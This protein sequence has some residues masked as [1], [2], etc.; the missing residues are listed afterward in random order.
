MYTSIHRA[1]GT[2]RGVVVV[3]PPF[4]LERTHS[5]PTLVRWSRY[6]AS[7]GFDVVRM[8]VRGMGESTGEFADQDLDTWADDVRAVVADAAAWAGGVPVM[9]HGVRS[10]GLIAAYACRDRT[11]GG[12]LL[13]DPPSSG[14]AMLQEMLRRKLAADYV[15]HT[16]GTRRTRVDYV[17]ELQSGGTVDVEGYSWPERLWRTAG[18]VGDVATL[19]D[20]RRDKVVRCGTGQTAVGSSPAAVAVRVPRPPFW[21]ESAQLRPDLSELFSVSLAWIEARA[22]AHS[23]SGRE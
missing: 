3:V 10:G 2:R 18:A 8:D 22:A 19:L 12:V 9:I 5:Y 21:A 4:G 23:G 11:G 15:E 20:A 16:G 6:L 13:W 1:T 17:R 14:E 7:A